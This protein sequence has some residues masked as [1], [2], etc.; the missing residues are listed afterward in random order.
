MNIQFAYNTRQPIIV[1]ILRTIKGGWMCAAQ[2][3]EVFLPGSQ[4]Y[5][6]LT[7]YESVI[8]KSVKVLVQSISDRGAIVSHKDF[9]KDIFERKD[10]LRGLKEAQI[11]NGTIRGISDKGFFVEVM[12]II[13]YMP[14]KE[15]RANLDLSVNQSIDVA[16]SNCDIDKGYLVLSERYCFLLKQKALAKEK[17]EDSRNKALKAFGNINIEDVLQCKIIKK[18]ASGYLLMTDNSVRGILET[19]EIPPR[20]KCKIGDAINVMVYDLNPIH[21]TFRGSITRLI[22]RKN[23]KY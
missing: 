10:V 13:G 9:I 2:E 14:I 6:D 4:L 18:L 19:C 16:V 1:N 20:Q 21:G 15:V 7:D 5:K 17:R 22:N 12:G 3:E 8:G 23:K 11:L